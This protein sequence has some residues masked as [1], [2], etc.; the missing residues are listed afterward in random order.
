MNKQHESLHNEILV[1]RSQQKQVDAF[2]ELVKCWQKRLWRH[3]FQITR[4]E[5]ASWDIVQDTWAKVIKSLGKL[6]DPAAFPGWVIRITNNLAID[7]IR[8]EMRRRKAHELYEK[9][10]HDKNLQHNS[11]FDI[12]QEAM[13]KLCPSEHT[14]LSF[15]YI[16]GFSL[17]EISTTLGIPMG[18]AKSRLHY[19]RKKLK[20][21]LEG[22]L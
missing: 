4:D 1:L 10:I 13:N 12:I 19:A 15:F 14:I 22:K 7:W 17:D 16:E 11:T 6:E 9:S 5:N 21:F 2:E 3:A 8:K 18:T 20:N